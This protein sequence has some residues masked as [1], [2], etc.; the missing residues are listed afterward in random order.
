MERL[1]D[2][3][4]LL[5]DKVV[6]VT[7]GS[8]G[9]GRAIAHEAAI[10]GARAVVINSKSGSPEARVNV[11]SLLSE[12]VGCGSLALWIPG[13]IAR[14]ET[15]VELVQNAVVTFGRV[16][17]VV[18][19]AGI[20]ADR[21]LVRMSDEDWKD[22]LETNLFGAFYVTRAAVRQM[23]R[24]RPT[25]G[26]IV[27]VSSVVSEG[28]SGQA[29]YVAAKAGMEGFARTVAKEYESRGVRV[30]VIAP[31]LVKTDMVA[32]LDE[33]QTEAALAILGG[34]M[35]SVQEVARE[36]VKLAVSNENFQKLVKVR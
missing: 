36:V 6:V 33:R 7:G 22:V 20:T 14:P 11:E 27:F 9:I 12:I 19:N 28:N 16:D 1:A 23:I 26:S 13:D 31:G 8:R 24:Q 34:R 35:L 3:E 21:L 5:A 10:S 15:A 25:G 18:N 32:K 2:P 29:N 30:A 17:V 4:R